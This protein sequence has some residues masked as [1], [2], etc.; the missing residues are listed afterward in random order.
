VNRRTTADLWLIS[1]ERNLNQ[2]HNLKAEKLMSEEPTQNLPNNDLQLILARLDSIDSR[3][4]SLETRMMTLEEKVDRRL[5]ETR[6]IWESVL[7]QLKEMNTRL[8]K[9]ENEN[10]DF[11][12]M[13][14]ST[15]S[16]MARMQDGLE[17]RVERLEGRNPLP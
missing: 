10:N 15:F 12:R 13:F 2:V 7:E 9:V 5:Q 14:R 1:L 8:T 16:D 3:L 17:E 11:R 6:P 4:T